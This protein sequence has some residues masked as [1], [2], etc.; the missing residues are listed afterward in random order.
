LANY[1]RIDPT[2]IRLIFVLGFFLTGSAT[3]WL[4]LVMWIVIPEEPL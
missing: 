2:V 3:F 1:F 4:Y